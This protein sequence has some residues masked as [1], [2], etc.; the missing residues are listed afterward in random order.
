MNRCEK[1]VGGGAEA[2]GAQ[3]GYPHVAHSG[4]AFHEAGARILMTVI[5]SATLEPERG[6]VF[7]SLL[8]G[9]LISF[10]LILVSRC[11][12]PGRPWQSVLEHVFPPPALQ[13]SGCGSAMILSS[14]FFELLKTA[15]LPPRLFGRRLTLTEALSKTCSHEE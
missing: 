5:K 2:K 8:G 1:A 9:I 14:S 12:E 7:R 6:P 11:S 10:M 15:Q 4:S 3:A 13:N